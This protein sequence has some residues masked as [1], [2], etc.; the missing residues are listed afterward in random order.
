MGRAGWGLRLPLVLALGTSLL[1]VA[2]PATGL[3]AGDLADTTLR[4]ANYL[5]SQEEY[6]R[7]IGEYQRYLFLAPEGEE[8]P[9]AALRLAECYA[10][11]K[12]WSEALGALTEFMRAYGSS[13]LAVQAGMLKARML[14][15]LG[16]GEEAREEL[17][18]LLETHPGEPVAAEVWYLTAISL[19]RESRWLEADEALRQIGPQSGRFVAAQGMRQVLA[20]ASTAERKDPAVAGL[21]A[22]VLPGAGHLYCD[23]PGDGAIAFVFTGAFTWA[24]VEAFQQD[25]DALGIGLGFI[26]LSFYGG[27]IFSAVNVAHKYNDREEHRLQLRLAP[28]EQLSLEVHPGPAPSVRLTLSF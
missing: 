4:F 3:R 21:L 6:Y 18:H 1:C 7:A 11:G 15:E 16:K 9:F 10:R 23:R 25:H 5:F 19:A 8:A 20:Q 24:T 27:N 26:A 14:I 2:A 28:Y 12:R 22:A 17:R 13:P